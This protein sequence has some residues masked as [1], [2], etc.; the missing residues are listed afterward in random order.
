M[1]IDHIE[2]QSELAIDLEV[3]LHLSL[4]LDRLFLVYCSIIPIVHIKVSHV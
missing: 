1:M 3:D 4:S 2:I